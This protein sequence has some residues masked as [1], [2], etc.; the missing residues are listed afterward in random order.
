MVLCKSTNYF[1]ESETT[2]LSENAGHQI[3]KNWQNFF[4]NFVMIKE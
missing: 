3:V 2:C 1:W 4:T